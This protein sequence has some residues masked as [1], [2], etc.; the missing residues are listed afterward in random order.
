[1]TFFE[2]VLKTIT[3][4]LIVYIVIFGVKILVNFK[5]YNTNFKRF[6]AIFL[7]VAISIAVVSV[8]HDYELVF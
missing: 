3:A 4:L 2:V 5:L 6:M 7:I 8:L 1:M